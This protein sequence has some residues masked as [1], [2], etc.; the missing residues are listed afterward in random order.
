MGYEV[1]V[2]KEVYIC[3][4]TFNTKEELNRRIRECEDSISR[5]REQLK[6]LVFMTEPSKFYD[7]VKYELT[8]DFDDIMEELSESTIRLT[9]LWEFESVWDETHDSS[10]RAILPINPF[11]LKNARAYMGGDLMEHVLEDGS[12]LPDDWWDVY[13]GFVPLEKCSF[14]DKIK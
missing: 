1:W 12:E 9:R 3:G 10:G 2:N 13:H 7:D 4:E 6:G 5:C 8:R 14:K 11:E